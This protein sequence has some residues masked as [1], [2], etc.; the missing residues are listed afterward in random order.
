MQ[1]TRLFSKL[2]LFTPVII[3]IIGFSYFVDSGNIFKGQKHYEDIISILL[4]GQNVAGDDVHLMN[5]RIFQKEFITRLPKKKDIIA[6]GSSQIMQINS[7]MFPGYSFFNSGVS[8]ATIEDCM[9]IYWLYRKKGM[10]PSK[11]IFGLNAWI[12][13]KFNGQTRYKTLLTEYN[14][15]WDY[16]SGKTTNQTKKKLFIEKYFALISPSYFQ[17][18]F[19][20]WISSK[21]RKPFYST[22]KSAANEDLRRFDGSISYRTR[23]RNRSPSEVYSEAVTAVSPDRSRV[24]YSLGNFTRLDPNLTGHFEKL[25]KLM[26]KD[27][28]EVI[29]VLPAYHPEVYSRLVKN[30]NYRII[31][32]AERYFITYAKRNKIS[33]IGSFNPMVSNL[34]N[35]DFYDSQHQREESIIK[36]TLLAN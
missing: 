27:K 19:W 25:I 15:L 18:S 29:F 17:A 12:L 30:S 3:M 10:L 5:E 32:D 28:V 34:T 1:I 23:Y 36:M 35:S 20:Q 8:G 6:L 11:I 16:V 14:E 33:V 4:K 24:F 21:E 31:V 22:I 26:Q 2:L 13:N 9:A 7:S